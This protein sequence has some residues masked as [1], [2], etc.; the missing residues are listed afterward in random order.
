ML[1]VWAALCCI[2]M[3]DGFFI[4]L[5]KG[6]ALVGGGWTAL[7]GLLHTGAK[8]ACAGGGKDILVAGFLW[9]G[10]FGRACGRFL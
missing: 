9:T 10:R 5:A 3:L 2:D 8:A 1:S 6:L 4:G 7:A